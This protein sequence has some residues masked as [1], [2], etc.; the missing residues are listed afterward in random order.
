MSADPIHILLSKSPLNIEDVEGF[1]SAD[2]TGALSFFV[3]KVRDHTGNKE[4][5]RLEYEAYE[6]MAVKEMEL[7]A[8]QIVSDY[9]VE[10]VAIHHRVGNLMIGD[11]AVII[12]VSAP[13]RKAAIGACAHA[14]ESLKKTVPIWKKEV[15]VDGE[16]WV[17]A[18]P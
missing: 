12:G 7:I 2:N 14:I 17:T 10:K 15:F 9:K 13:H 3:G 18:N 11:I 5:N 8:N 1:I 4:V 16:S 6:P